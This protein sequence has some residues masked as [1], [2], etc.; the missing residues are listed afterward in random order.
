MGMSGLRS[1]IERLRSH[2]MYARGQKRKGLSD[3]GDFVDFRSGLDGVNTRMYYTLARGSVAVN[4]DWMRPE[5]RIDTLPPKPMVERPPAPEP[6][7]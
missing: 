5:I 4:V 7:H 2:A 3:G 6:R 1:V